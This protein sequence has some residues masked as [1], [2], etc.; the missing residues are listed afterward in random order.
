MISV[1]ILGFQSVHGRPAAPSDTVRTLTAL[2]PGTVEG[3]IRDVT[4][5][6]TRDDVE[7][8]RVADF[9]GCGLLVGTS[10]ADVVRRGAK[11]A[12]CPL[13]LV[14]PCGVTFDRA[15]TDELAV[16]ND[17]RH[18]AMGTTKAGWHRIVPWRD[19]PSGLIAPRQWLVDRCPAGFRSLARALR[20]L[21]WFRT[22]AWSG[23]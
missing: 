14:L 17:E 1:L 18:Y 12:R 9:A 4:L 20:P 11:Q 15:L 19:P 16:V 23:D 5:L 2:V 22:Q 6:A 13:V 21:R 7:L 8:A 10:F 3:S